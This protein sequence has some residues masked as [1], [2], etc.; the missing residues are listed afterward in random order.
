M[1]TTLTDSWMA[2]KQQLTICNNRR[3]HFT[4]F[5]NCINLRQRLHVHL[6]ACCTFNAQPQ[7]S[8][9]CNAYHAHCHFQATPQV[10]AITNNGNCTPRV[11]QKYTAR[12]GQRNLN[13]VCHKC[14]AKGHI[15]RYCTND[16]VCQL[17]TQKGNDASKCWILF[18]QSNF[19]SINTSQPNATMN[20]N[21][22]EFNPK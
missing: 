14:D 15:K 2:L 22:T 11:S 9:N 5:I 4:T 6:S 20:P 7:H 17:F 21:F 18:S 1:S 12:G 3:L 16:V 19:A 13:I 10:N 8:A